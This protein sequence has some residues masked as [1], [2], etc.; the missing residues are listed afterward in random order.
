MFAFWLPCFTCLYLPSPH[1]KETIRTKL[2]V[3]MFNQQNVGR[4]RLKLRQHQLSLGSFVKM[5]CTWKHAIIRKLITFHQHYVV[6]RIDLENGLL[7]SITFLSTSACDYCSYV[8]RSNLKVLEAQRNKWKSLCC[9]CDSVFF[10][11]ATYPHLFAFSC[12]VLNSA[13][14]KVLR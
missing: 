4:S 2:H 14:V 1:P 12:G 6:P 9:R 10:R 3:K 11:L 13:R 5:V 7:V 8:L